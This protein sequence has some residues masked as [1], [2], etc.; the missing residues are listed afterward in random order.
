VRNRN[1]SI[2]ARELQTSLRM[3]NITT[4]SSLST[5][6]LDT[7]TLDAVT[8][9]RGFNFNFGFRFDFGSLFGAAPVQAPAQAPRRPAPS[10]SRTRTTVRVDTWNQ[11]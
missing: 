10:C 1:T 4:P 11:R 7:Q 6:I 8:G 5:Q 2:R 3:S 9:G